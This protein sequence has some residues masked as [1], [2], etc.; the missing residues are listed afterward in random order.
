MGIPNQY[1]QAL[2]DCTVIY[3]KLDVHNL[4][5]FYAPVSGT[6]VARIDHLEP[7]RMSQYH[8]YTTFKH[9]STNYAFINRRRKRQSD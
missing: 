6:V 1:L 9:E 4:H 7:L 8:R 5:R 3:L 2:K